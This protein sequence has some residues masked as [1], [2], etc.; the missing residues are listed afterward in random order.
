[1]DEQLSKRV[2]ERIITSCMI[3]SHWFSARMAGNWLKNG[4]NMVLTVVLRLLSEVRWDEDAVDDELHASMSMS[5]S[6]EQV[7]CPGNG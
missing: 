2:C 6:G 7:V 3:C 5:L 4:E 1:M